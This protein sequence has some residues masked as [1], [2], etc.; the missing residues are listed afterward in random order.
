LDGRLRVL[1]KVS[2]PPK[3][4]GERDSATYARQIHGPRVV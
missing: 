3:E 1:K 2:G 4:L